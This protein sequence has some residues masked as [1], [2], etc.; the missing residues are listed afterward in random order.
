MG[1]GDS[2]DISTLKD[3]T[4]F[5][6]AYGTYTA[7][8]YL[9]GYGGCIDSAMHQVVITNPNDSRF[10]YD[11]LNACNRLNV[12]FDLKPPPHT[13]FVLDFGDGKA[14]SSQNLTPTHLYTSPA[15]YYPTF[16][17]TD[18]V[19]CQVVLGPPLE[20][21]VIGAQP[22]FGID[23][24]EFCDTGVVNF[25][26]YT[27]GNDPVVSMIW[28]FGDGNSSTDQNPVYRYSKPGEHIAKLTVNTA[29]GCTDFITDTIRVY[30]TP[31]VSINTLDTICINS[32]VRFNGILSLDDSLVSYNW[33]FSDGQTSTI[34]DPVIVFNKTGDFTVTLNSK[35]PFG[36]SDSAKTTVNVVPLP[37]VTVIGSPTIIAGGNT[38][39]PV[40]YSGNIINYTWTPAN[41][42]SCADCPSPIA[43]PSK[44][45][46]YKIAVSDVYGCSN[47]GEVTVIV[48]CG[49]KNVY[50]P[51][52][53][54]PNNDGNN[55]RFYPRGA[56]LNRIQSMRIFNRWGETVYQKINFMANDSSA[57]WDGLYKGKK[58][59]TDVYVYVIE[60]V[61][62]NGE[63][64]P[65]KGNIM[66]MK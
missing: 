34:K 20:I 39:L 36:C 32:P 7:K 30:Q 21:K 1:F 57:G 42:L 8:L 55:D 60:V 24:K 26:D 62:E 46:T 58:A 29:S 38:P 2:S 13:R 15:Y 51:N 54:S 35:V 53:F 5:Y 10:V 49:D 37:S 9:T 14:D 3:P 59:D 12:N 43:K 61:C 52:T 40:T 66:L 48:V 23:K 25:T 44:T 11:P 65:F 28:D 63:I 41:S 47:T 31:E 27:I 6:N 33:K 19:G 4:H 50:L 18:S 17:M 22:L 16:S 64:I 56:G 45:T